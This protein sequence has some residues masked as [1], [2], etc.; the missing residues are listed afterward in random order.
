MNN[1]IKSKMA[2]GIVTGSLYIIFGSFQVIVGL[3]FNFKF[4]EY[5]FIQNDLIGGFILILIGLI[6]LFG[7]KELNAGINEG[8]AYIYIAIFLS[9]IFL[10]I[11]LLIMAADAIEA[12]VIVSND[13]INWTPLNDLKPGI[14]LGIL[15]LI[16]FIIWRNKFSIDRQI[17]TKL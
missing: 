10:V 6:F 5:L 3:G 1:K 9:L 17:K 14:Y 11:Y 8:V 13:F 16:A 7:I 2:F 12:Y 4:T 15:P